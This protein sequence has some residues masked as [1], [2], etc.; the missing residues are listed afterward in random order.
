MNDRLRVMV[1]AVCAGV[2][3]AEGYDEGSEQTVSGA[4]LATG[5]PSAGQTFEIVAA[6]RDGDVSIFKGEVVG[7]EPVVK[8]GHNQTDFEFLRVRASRTGPSPAEAAAAGGGAEAAT[9]PCLPAQALEAMQFVPRGGGGFLRVRGSVEVAGAG[10]PFDGK[11]LVTG[12]SHRFGLT[13]PDGGQFWLPEVGDEV[14]VAFA[15]GDP[16]RP[17][18]LGALWNPAAAPPA[19]ACARRG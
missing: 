19:P 17:V 11:Y 3:C 2:G 12:V 10:A 8:A 13:R 6:G 1:F 16:D 5:G 7:I 4:L 18:I 15:G 9:L 14:L